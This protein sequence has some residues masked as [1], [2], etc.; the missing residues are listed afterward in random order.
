MAAADVYDDDDVAPGDG[1]PGTLA[2]AVVA[3]VVVVDVDDDVASGDGWS[4]DLAAAV[5][6]VADVTDV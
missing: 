1:W 5:V 4:G 2:A 3:V 6:T